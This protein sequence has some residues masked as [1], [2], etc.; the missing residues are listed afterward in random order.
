MA[1][2]PAT[3]APARKGCEIL[4]FSE[5]DASFVSAGHDRRRQRMFNA[6]W[7][8]AGGVVVGAVA[9]VWR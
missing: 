5:A 9:S 2:D 7:P 6:T 1:I 8:V 4:D 3:D